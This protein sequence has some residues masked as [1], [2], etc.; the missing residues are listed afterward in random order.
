MKLLR[1]RVDWMEG[2]GNRPI[3]Y[4]LLQ[5]VPPRG[6]MRFEQ[7]GDLYF[8][9]R[10]GF[11]AFY[12]W[13][14]TQDNGF[15]GAHLLITMITGENRV[16]QGPWSSRSSAMNDVG[17]GPCVEVVYSE[18]VKDFTCGLGR[19]G[20]VLVSLLRDNALL[21]D[22][23][24]GYT[25]RP[26]STY[27]AEVAFPAGSTFSLACSGYVSEPR[28]D[29]RFQDFV[30]VP[31]LYPDGMR[32]DQLRN[33]ILAAQ[34]ANHHELAHVIAARYA[35]YHRVGALESLVALSGYEPAVKLPNGEFWTK[36]D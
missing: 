24:E 20:A 33:A 3:L 19:G 16:L 5:D 1:G 22:I 31:E 27:A 34:A 21:I 10:D 12:S 14:G 8:A 2:R 26:G 9:E 29:G 11:C 32:I 15:G 30:S 18:H 7:R 6:E 23:G 25:W 28:K 36:P 13:N 35:R 4:L 17:F